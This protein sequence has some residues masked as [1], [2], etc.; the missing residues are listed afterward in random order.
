MINYPDINWQEQCKFC[1]KG[2]N[3]TYCFKNQSLIEQLQKLSNYRGTI[4]F[5]C[6]YFALDKTKTNNE[7][8]EK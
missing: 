8:N 1:S 2:I 5:E 3:T 7:N 6:E 4:D